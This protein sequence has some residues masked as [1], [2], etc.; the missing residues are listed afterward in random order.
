[1]Q[2]AELT[3]LRADLEAA[4]RSPGDDEMFHALIERSM[5]LLMLTDVDFATEVGTNR[6]SINRWKNGKNAPHPAVRPRV[7]A[8]LLKRVRLLIAREE[9]A[10]RNSITPTQ[11]VSLPVQAAQ[12]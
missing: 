1:M 2:L 7:Y 5:R 8:L 12:R 3:Q 4:S 9:R 10:A 6:S 11:A